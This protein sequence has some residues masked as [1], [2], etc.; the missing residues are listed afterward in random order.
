MPLFR[1][2]PAH[3]FVL[4]FLC[5]WDMGEVKI[6]RVF[7]FFYF[8]WFQGLHMRCMHFKDNTGLLVRVLQ[9][10]LLHVVTFFEQ[11]ELC[12]ELIV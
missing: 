5:P 2:S 4:P 8:D 9:S 11:E 6:S 3:N 1:C 10:F 7:F 12:A